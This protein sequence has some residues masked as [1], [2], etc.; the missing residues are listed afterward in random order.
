MV[1][2]QQTIE[3]E[4]ATSGKGLFTGADVSLKLS[5]APIDHGLIFQRSDLPSK[6]SWR[7][8]FSAVKPT[9]RCTRLGGLEGEI[10]LVEHLLSTLYAHGVDNLLIEVEGPEIPAGDGSALLFVELLKEGRIVEQEAPKRF[11]KVEEPLF[12]SQGETHLVALPS[13]T[14]RV[15]YTLHYPKSPCLRSQYYTMEVTPERFRA[16]IAPCRTFSLYEEIAPLLEK[17]LIKGGGLENALVIQGEKVLNPGGA[18][19]PDEAGRH[20]VLDLIGDLALLGHPLKA[21]IIALCSGHASNVAFAQ[22]ISEHSMLE[23]CSWEILK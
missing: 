12:W 4:V 17:G 22:V 18:R 19:F 11:F 20:K 9:P 23:S 16:E 1:E 2:Q 21:H 13:D 5:P 7:A 3:K 15:S 6:P 14:F 8:H 10:F